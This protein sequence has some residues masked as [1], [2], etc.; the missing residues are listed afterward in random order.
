MTKKP[1]FE[2][3]DLGEYPEVKQV[4]FPREIHIAFAVCGTSCGNKGFIV[5]GQ[6]QVC[7]YCGKLM[8]RT[9]VKKYVLA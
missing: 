5:D 6:T 1:L 3:Y 7:E 2:A 4:E 9:E 8:Y